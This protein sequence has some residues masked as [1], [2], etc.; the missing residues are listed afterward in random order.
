MWEV[1]VMKDGPLAAEFENQL[2]GR[3]GSLS[4]LHSAAGQM[5]GRIV[6]AAEAARR[7]AV[8]LCASI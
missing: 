3:D 8:F 7:P 1:V 2:A 4:A 6:V 5:L